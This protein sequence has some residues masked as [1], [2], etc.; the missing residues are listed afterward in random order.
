M[1]RT[2]CE[3]EKKILNPLVGIL[4]QSALDPAHFGQA[5]PFYGHGQTSKLCAHLITHLFACPKYPL[6][7]QLDSQVPPLHS[8]CVA[9]DQAPFIRHIH[10]P[11]APAEA[12]GT[13]PN[14][15]GILRSPSVHL[16]IH[17]RIK[18][19]MH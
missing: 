11:R 12:K 16:R 7:L 8:L 10:R 18:G 6:I 19:H 13:F 9:H 17:A 5:G 14:R 3:T 1:S 4:S 2:F 15:S